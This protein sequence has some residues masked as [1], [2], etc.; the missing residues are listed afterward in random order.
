MASADECAAME[1][2][3]ALAA[4]PVNE[5]TP[6]PRVGAVLIDDTGK[7][8]GQGSH[9]GAG[10]PHAEVV[11]L[12]EAGSLANGATA[13]VT[14]EP[15]RHTGRTGP[16]VQALIA[17]GVRRVVFAQA[18]PNPVAAH[19]ADELRRAGV[20][21][22]SGVL[23]TEAA[24]LN[25]EWA[26]SV[27]RARPFVTLKIAATLDGR[28]A[29]LDGSSQWITSEAARERVH[30]LR[31]AVDAVLVGTG[32]ALAD[33]P[34]LTDRRPNSVASS[35]SSIEQR[36]QR[37][38]I[39]VVMGRRQLPE[40]AKLLA[41]SDLRRLPTHDVDVALKTLF[42]DGVRHLLVEG[43]PTIA[44][45]FLQA[46]R[47][48]RLVWFT[49]PKLLGAGRAAVADLGINSIDET[50]EWRITQATLEGPDVRL[51]LEPGKGD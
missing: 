51:V 7:T 29:A 37:A 13:V 48:D 9:R 28:V 38:P 14:L 16:C 34:E 5:L 41:R 1:L 11:A 25:V 33:D 2:A 42:D 17:A 6:N 19:G 50:L 18:D 39:P 4:D 47:V 21:V 12:Q 26:L 22:E 46:K 27:T 40:G 36:R 24:A 32:T 23:A 15:C 49:A 30:E 8:I 35:D 43:G 31:S 3:I 44:T 20:D 10:N 45:A